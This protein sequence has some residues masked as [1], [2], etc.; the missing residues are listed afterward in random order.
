MGL[1]GMPG[2]W[3][4]FMRALFHKLGTFVVVYMDDICIFSRTI[5][6]PRRPRSCSMR[7]VAQEE[8]LRSTL[9]MFIWSQRN[10]ILRAYGFRIWSTRRHKEN[11]FYCNVPNAVLSQGVAEFSRISWVLPTIRLQFCTTIASSSRVNQ[12]RY[13]MELGGRSA[14]SV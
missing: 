6:G 9:Q 2:V 5:G 7:S 13:S 12:T 11:R 10:Y 3:S 1:S 4:R 8:A 14:T